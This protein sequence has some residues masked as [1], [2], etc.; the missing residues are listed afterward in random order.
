M[1]THYEAA[2]N[3]IPAIRALQ[4]AAQ[5]AIG[6]QSYPAA[7]DLLQNALRL[8]GNLPATEQTSIHRELHQEL[9]AVT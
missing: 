7:A 5:F 3:W 4:S 9:T 2:G 6:R 1:A 8:A